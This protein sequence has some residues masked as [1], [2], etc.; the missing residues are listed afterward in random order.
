VIVTL[1]D[2]VPFA[3]APVNAGEIEP[4]ESERLQAP[5]KEESISPIASHAVIV[6]GMGEPAVSF[7][8]LLKVKWSSCPKRGSGRNAMAD[9]A[10]MIYRFIETKREN[11]S[12]TP[13]E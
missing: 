11:P 10:I 8:T 3:N 1:P 13:G 4:V 2:Q 9:N 12:P 5:V 7:G 6:S